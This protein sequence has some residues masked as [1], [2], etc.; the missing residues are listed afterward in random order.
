MYKV[1]QIMELVDTQKTALVIEYIRQMFRD[2]ALSEKEM[3]VTYKFNVVSGTNQYG[4]PDNLIR[5]SKVYVLD[6]DSS[7][8][9][10]PEVVGSI[11]SS[12]NVET[13]GG[14][15]VTPTTSTAW[16]TFTDGDDTPSVA[17]GLLFKTANTTP[18][19]IT[20]FDLPAY[21]GQ[22]IIVYFGDG[23]TTIT[24]DVTKISLEGGI[25]RTFLTGDMLEFINNGGVWEAYS[26][27]VA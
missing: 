17:A 24:H 25:N 23:V 27:R 1:S 22:H 8:R 9:Q 6:S 20:D 19:T 26:A 14:T 10:I 2:L 16:I 18:T 7:Y 5:L 11:E 4:L 21:D 3:P 13:E 15:V 12:L